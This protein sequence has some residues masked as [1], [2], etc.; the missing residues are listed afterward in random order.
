M[1]KEREH[2]GQEIFV[3]GYDGDQEVGELAMFDSV[4]DL[5]E[6]LSNMNPV[7]ETNLTVVHGILT[8]A[9]YIP[10]GPGRG[11]YVIVVDPLDKDNGC[12][13]EFTNG[14]PDDLAD[15]IEGSILKNKHSELGS[16]T[17]DNI[18]I[19]Y[20]YEVSMCYAVNEDEVDD[21]IIETSQKI[22]DGANEM[23]EKILGTE[24]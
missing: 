20:G 10:E 14:D 12:I 3:A 18:F 13:Y 21:E 15:L 6:H 4:C 19:L 7:S 23:R 17:I 5:N 2:I 8:S 11:V 24:E 1:A 9:E 16:L 22:A